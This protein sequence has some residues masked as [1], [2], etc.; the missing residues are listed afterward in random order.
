M[1]TRISLILALLF[2]SFCAFSQKNYTF[3]YG[4]ISLTL[5]D[6]GN[7]EM[8]RYNSSGTAVSR[9]KGSYNLYGEGSPTETLKINFQGT[10]YRYELIRDGFG[11]PSKL[12]DS[13]TREYSLCKATKP[14]NVDNS[15]ANNMSFFT[16]TFV[17]PQDKI[18]VVITSNS[19]K[20]NGVAY[21][22][23]KLYNFQTTCG[24][25]SKFTQEGEPEIR[26]SLTRIYLTPN[27]CNEPETY[28]IGKPNY[29]SLEKDDNGLSFPND[30]KQRFYYLNLTIKVGDFFSSGS[31]KEVKY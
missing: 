30:P 21:K 23:G 22:N 6:G 15:S 17:L 5:F 20:L 8:V 19:G 14:S 7:A 26:Q 11:T 31:V 2:I 24:Q 9:V 29:I 18:K 1:N 16:G 12:F 3:C 25:A 10:E 28:G 4:A 27:G 13:Q